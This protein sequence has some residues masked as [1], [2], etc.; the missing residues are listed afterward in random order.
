MNPANFDAAYP[1]LKGM[2]GGYANNSNDAGGETY[3]GIARNFWPNEPLWPIV[4]RYKAQVGRDAKAL[5]KL[6]AADPEAQAMLKNF[7]RRNFWDAMRCDELDHA[8]AME[9]LDL[10]VNAGVGTAVRSLQ[11]LL[12]IM[13]KQG[14]LWPDLPGR[15]KMGD[16]TIAAVQAFAKNYSWSALADLMN[17]M[18]AKHYIECCQK[19][20]QNEEFAWGWLERR[21]LAHIRKQ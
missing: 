11:D 5:N 7:Y 2:E 18:Q 8:V 21:V 19:R 10:G 15:G 9:M 6:L 13:N 17:L 4:D 1:E 3:G 12:D 16:L 14:S 20:S